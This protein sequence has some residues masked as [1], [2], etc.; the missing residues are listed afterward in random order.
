MPLRGECL[1]FSL[2]ALEAIDL[3][4]S[5]A[6]TLSWKTNEGAVVVKRSGSNVFV[7]EGLP[8]GVDPGPLLTLL[9]Q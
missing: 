2:N 9:K 3:L 6:R 8:D 5:T 1:Q 7:M 4:V